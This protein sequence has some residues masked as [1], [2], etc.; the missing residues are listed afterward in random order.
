MGSSTSTIGQLMDLVEHQAA[1]I[2]ATGTGQGRFDDSDA[3]DAV[4]SSLHRG[5]GESSNESVMRAAE[6][7]TVARAHEW[8]RLRV[9]LY[10]IAASRV[11]VAPV[12]GATV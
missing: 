8:S 1:V 3:D 12:Q 6:D 11:P 7:S 9:G 4:L 5:L 2:V 10:E